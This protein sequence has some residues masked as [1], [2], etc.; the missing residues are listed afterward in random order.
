MNCN[1][2]G[3]RLHETEEGSICGP[4]NFRHFGFGGGPYRETVVFECPDCNENLVVSYDTRYQDPP[5]RPECWRCE[6]DELEDAEDDWP[7]S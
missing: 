2:C 1:S 4:C 6:D 7:E 5:E 3:R